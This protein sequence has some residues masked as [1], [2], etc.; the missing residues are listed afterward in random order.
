MSRL[1][2]IEDK[3]GDNHEELIFPCDCGDGDYLRITWD[4]DP[5]WRVLWVEAWG[6]R[7]GLWKRIKGAWRILCNQS[8]QHT[9]ILLTQEVV[10]GLVAFLEEK[11]VPDTP[12][13]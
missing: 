3:W 1:T 13:A 2:E 10:D 8:W 6:H 9:E 4:E 7:K 12:E 5:E 11:N